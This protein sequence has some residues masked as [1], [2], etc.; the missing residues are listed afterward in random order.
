MKGS[1][2]A[3]SHH[4][5]G[6][7]LRHPFG[8]MLV[9]GLGVVL[10]LLITATHLTFQTNRLDLIASGDHYRQLG[11]AYD[12][13]FEDLPGDVIVVIRSERP[14]AAKAFAT[15]LAQRWAT[16]PH[17]DQVLY[18][19]NV[20]TLKQKALLYL[21]PDDLMALRQ[22]LQNHQAF[23]EELTAAPTLQNLLALIN[24]EMSTALVGQVFT[25][26]LEE[27]HQAKEPPDL[28]LLVALLQHMNQALDAPHVY[29]SPWASLF[30][31]DVET[32][33]QDGF[34]WSDDKHLLFVLVQPKREEGE[35]NR[36]DKAVQQIRADVDELRKVHPDVEVGITGK[37]ILDADEM[38]VAA[39]DTGLATVISVVGVTLLYF[40]LFK[41]VVRPLLA[42]AALLIGICWALGFTS[43]T[44]GHLNILSMVFMP[45]LLGLGIDYGSYFISRY[46]EE[47]RAGKGLQ[48]A[49]AQ[50]FV[51]TGPGIVATALTTALT[52]GTLLLTGFKGIAELGF[53]GGSGILLAALA[54]FT[55]LPALLTCYEK[56]RPVRGAAPQRKFPEKHRGGYLEPLYRHPWAIVAASVLLSGLALLALGKVEMDLNLLHLQAKGTESIV[57]VQRIFESTRRSVLYGEMVADSL[58]DVKRKEAALRALPSVAQVESV[59]SVIPEDQPRK[60]RLIKEL[61]PF[62]AD[63]A[64]QRDTAEA[65]DLEALRTILGRL[66]FKMVEDGEAAGELREGT[67]REQMHEVRRLI[68]QFDETTERL[69]QTA[70]LQAL[71]TFQE[72][73]SRDLVEQVTLLQA[74]LQAEPVTIHDLPSELQTRYVGKTGH[75]RLFVYPAEDIWEFTPLTRFV[76]QIRSVDP[77]VLGTPIGNFEY[78]RGIKEAYAQ[79]GLYAFLGIVGLTL[80]TFRAVRPT[81]LALIPLAVGSLWILGFMGLFHVTFNVAN[82][83]VLPLIM[84]PAVESGIMIV[85]RYREE[86]RTRQRPLPLP[87]STGQAVVFSSLSTIIGFGSLMI[88]HHRGIFSIGLLL[89][90]G[91]ASVLLASITTLPSLLSILSSRSRKRADVPSERGSLSP[92]GST[93]ITGLPRQPWPARRDRIPRIR[94][95]GSPE[96]VGIGVASALDADEH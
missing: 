45:M 71:A 66:Q 78:T 16:N 74:N 57:W 42:L 53:I 63:L 51:A 38:A 37:S 27:D 52:F 80:L 92:I 1:T 59:A 81:F 55:V 2:H 35:F 23:L 43:L 24:R 83:I 28:S 34:L 14:E 68:A 93:V 7:I 65:V 20:D 62:L 9:A 56:R 11:D 85:Y 41:G 32:R 54:T 22:K 26:F 88:S 40:G 33:G 6:I 3:M 12:R 29:Q 58:E 8:I 75:Y 61:P 96:T 15:A 84:A 17:I 73:L 48:E 76:D 39:R 90:L 60:M 49:M 89:T 69:G 21:S 25:G 4:F 5:A 91:V 77:D 36:F 30:A 72:E 31:K 95:L 46:M 18:R 44:I 82:L 50:T 79:A 64:L 94:R 10:A 19:I 87:Q 67:L 86:R 47:R 13:E 70:A